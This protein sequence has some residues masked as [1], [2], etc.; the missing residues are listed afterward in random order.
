VKWTP[1]APDAL[2]DAGH[3]LIQLLVLLAARVSEG[4]CLLPHTL[5]LQIS[6]ADGS[7]GAVDVVCSNNRVFSRPRRDGNLDLGIALRKG[8]ERRFD[9]A[10]HAAR[11]AGPVAVVEFQFLA[12]EDEGADAIL[13][14]VSMDEQ[15]GD[16]C[17]GVP[18]ALRPS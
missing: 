16:N 17:C 9:K 12:L 7:L 2:V 6:Y 5:C 15:K 1:D 18:E 8:G 10:V 4:F 14:Q 3:R 11:G 13:S